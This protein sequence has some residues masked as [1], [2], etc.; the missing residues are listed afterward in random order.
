MPEANHPPPSPPPADIVL[1]PIDLARMTD[2]YS[3]HFSISVRGDDVTVDFY[4]LQGQ[5]AVLQ[6]NGRQRIDA[7]H[8]ARVVV[9][10]ANFLNLAAAFSEGAKLVKAALSVPAPAVPPVTI[11]P[12]GRKND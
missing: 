2:V 7:L 10:G 6:P 4:Q 11:N 12:P 1:L 8:K 5:T 3:N 9:T